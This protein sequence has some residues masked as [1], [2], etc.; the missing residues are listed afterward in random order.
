MVACYALVVLVGWWFWWFVLAWWCV[1]V[2]EK[3]ECSML[4]IRWCLFG[5]VVMLVAGAVAATGASA[6]P[7]FS[8]NGSAVTA[9]TDGTFTSGTS[10]LRDKIAG[11]KVNIISTLDTGRFSL[12]PGVKALSRLATPGTRWKTK[13]PKK[14]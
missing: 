6:Q 4:R 12:E 14:S 9:L 11:I 1:G 3:G 8:V 2:I 7:F 13:K 5:V 10:H